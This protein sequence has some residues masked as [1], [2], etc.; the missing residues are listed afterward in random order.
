M[1][2]GSVGCIVQARM[3]SSRL[4]GKTLMEIAGK[5]M[6]G[7]MLE[8]LGGCRSLGSVVVATSTDAG[9]NAIADFCREKKVECFRGSENDVLER[10]YK[11]AKK[12]GFD[13]V[14][15]LT[16]DCPLIDPETVDRAVEK[17][18]KGSF[19]YLSNAVPRSFPR[20]L[21]VE[22]F[23]FRALEKAHREAKDAFDREHVTHYF[24]ANPKKFSIGSISA[25]PPLFRPELRLCVDTKEDVPLIE[26]IFSRFGSNANVEKVIE[27]IDNSPEMA[28]LS[29][30]QEA[31]YNAK[32]GFIGQITIR[33]VVFG[34]NQWIRVIMNQESARKNSFNQAEIGSAE[35]EN[36][37]RRKLADPEFRAFAIIAGEK[38]AGILRIDNGL[39]SVAID[40]SFRG[41]G[42]AFAAL[43]SLDLGDCVAEVKPENEAS[44]RL[45]KKLGFEEAS[46]EKEKIVFKKK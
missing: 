15:R 24:Y 27:F 20:G 12:H 33:P 17:F 46:R 37:W 38:P 8:R 31:E 18:L 1:E 11:C 5:P 22:V 9:D 34:D 10:Y 23:S 7:H 32:R 30:G 41:K 35:N 14:A 16:G 19:D 36:Y 39:V 26:A 4:P 40:E 29:R 44:A 13:V 3:G 2:K 45:F 28:A 6:L 43:S 25:A 21:D 42:I